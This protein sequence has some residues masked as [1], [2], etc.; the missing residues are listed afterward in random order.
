VRRCKG[1][2][3][4]SCPETV[5][6]EPTADYLPIMPHRE[7]QD[8]KPHGLMCPDGILHMGTVAPR[9]ENVNGLQPVPFAPA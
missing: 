3:E 5:A 8:A 2:A 6:H 1:A 9:A 7:N 4:E